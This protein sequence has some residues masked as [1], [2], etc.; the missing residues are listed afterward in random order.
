M[1]TNF[2]TKMLTVFLHISDSYLLKRTVFPLRFC[3]LFTKQIIDSRPWHKLKNPNFLTLLERNFGIHPFECFLTRES[4]KN[5]EMKIKIFLVFC[6]TKTILEILANFR[7][8]LFQMFYT[9]F[10]FETRDFEHNFIF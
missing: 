3:L 5:K 9:Y 1:S 6:G 8:D 2:D 7:F 10:L 4:Q